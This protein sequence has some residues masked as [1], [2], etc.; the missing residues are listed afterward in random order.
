MLNQCS[1]P[2]GFR[3]LGHFR[4]SDFRSVRSGMVMFSR[5][6]RLSFDLGASLRTKKVQQNSSFKKSN[7]RFFAFCVSFE[8]HFMP[9][10]FH[11][12]L[13]KVKLIL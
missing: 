6:F 3:V 10:R 5:N 9:P 11:H 7:F 8:V 4:V 12:F 2:S 1:G 13:E